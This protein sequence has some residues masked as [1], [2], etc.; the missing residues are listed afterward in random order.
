L[1]SPN[2]GD[3]PG[4]YQ[5]V[6]YSGNSVAEAPQY[7]KIRDPLPGEIDDCSNFTS[8]D[9]LV[10]FLKQHEAVRNNGYLDAGG[11]PTIG[12]GH[13][14]I[15]GDVIFGDT[16]S[17]TVTREDIKQLTRNRVNLRISDEEVDRL[18]RLDLVRFE[19]GVCQTI[20]AP[21]TQ[22]QFD[23][24]VSLSFNIG[25]GAFARSSV[26]S[27]V[28]TSQLNNIP[29]AWMRWITVSGVNNQGLVNRRRA[30]LST[31]WDSSN[32]LVA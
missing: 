10:Q 30:E 25:N 16:I 22:N 9:G 4:L 27:A 11:K 28:N 20:T 31:F 8:S 6:P 26:A 18:F 2:P 12:V 1:G 14:I 13:L 5:A 21:I 15:P 29:Q 23:G 32:L 3:L 17:G 19:K 7:I 24:M